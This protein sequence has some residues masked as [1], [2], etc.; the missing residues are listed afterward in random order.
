MKHPQKKTESSSA[1]LAQ[2]RRAGSRDLAKK[3]VNERT[4]MLVLYCRLAG[5]D[6][7]G[8]SRNG[9]LAHKL[10]QEFCQVLVDYVAAGH[11]SLYERINN[12]TERRRGIAQLADTLYP[13]I[14]HTTDSALTFN[15]KYDPEVSVLSPGF[16]EDLSTLGEEIAVRI[17]LEDQLLKIMYESGQ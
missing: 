3:L 1:V 11:F 10:L 14:A 7:H 12:G 13:R 17:E 8:E 6:S 9:T 4:E 16:F 5:L 15:D 2:D